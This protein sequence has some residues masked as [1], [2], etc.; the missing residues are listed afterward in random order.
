VKCD[1]KV[2]IRYLPSCGLEIL[3]KLDGK[4]RLNYTHRGDPADE[5]LTGEGTLSDLTVTKILER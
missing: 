5:T 3:R 1:A 4:L 2:T